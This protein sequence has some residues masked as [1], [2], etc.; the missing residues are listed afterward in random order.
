MYST[1]FIMTGLTWSL[2]K[3]TEITNY[4]NVFIVSS[5]PCIPN[6]PQQ[7]SVWGE[8]SCM[9]HHPGLAVSEITALHSAPRSMQYLVVTKPRGATFLKNHEIKR[10]YTDKCCCQ[11]YFFLFFF[12]KYTCT[13]VGRFD[14]WKAR[15]T[16]W[17]TQLYIYI[18][19]IKINE[20]F[21]FCF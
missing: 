2:W 6:L 19:A 20:S 12:L 5:L 18:S 8:S 13:S 21:C 3:A 7:G 17:L 14:H 1:I 11:D 4:I 15:W 16:V 10:S 9:H